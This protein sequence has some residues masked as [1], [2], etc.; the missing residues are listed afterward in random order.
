MR[1]ESEHGLTGSAVGQQ[2]QFG[3]LERT[4]GYEA[5]EGDAESAVLTGASDRPD[6]LYV[7]GAGQRRVVGDLVY[8][9]P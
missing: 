1:I 7:I 3:E 9:D 6:H 2:E 5:A 4:S 8:D